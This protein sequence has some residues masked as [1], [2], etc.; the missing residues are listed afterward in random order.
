MSRKHLFLY[1]LFLLCGAGIGYAI[2]STIFVAGEKPYQGAILGLLFG[3]L[4]SVISISLEKFVTKRHIWGIFGFIGGALVSRLM[5]GVLNPISVFI[6]LPSLPFDSHP[7][8]ALFLLRLISLCVFTF[9]GATVALKIEADPQLLQ[10]RSADYP[11]NT[12]ILDTS[13]IIDGRIADLCETGFLEGIFLIPQFVLQE[14]QYIA[15]SSDGMRRLRG[16]RGLDVLNRLQKVVNFDL[17][18]VDDDFPAIREVDAKIVALAKRITAKVV[19]NDF[20]LNKVAELQGVVVWNIN[21]LSNSL[22]PVVLPGE[23]M[24]LLV[25][26]EGKESSQGV[27]YLN[28]GTMVVIDEARRSIGKEVDATVTSVLQTASGRMIFARIHEEGDQHGHTKK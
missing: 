22:K 5:E 1:A 20:N 27:A 17:R 23:S 25:A 24:R 15:D 28:D 9:L 16:R 11:P 3:V 18:I 13:V 19:T 7:P 2:A 21:H 6:L 10:S 12:K 14:L 8:E 4:L 26:K